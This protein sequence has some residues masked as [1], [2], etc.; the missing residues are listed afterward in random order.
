MQRLCLHCAARITDAPPDPE[1]ILSNTSQ[2]FCKP[3]CE[4]KYYLKVRAET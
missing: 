4:T 3:A 2:L 1:A